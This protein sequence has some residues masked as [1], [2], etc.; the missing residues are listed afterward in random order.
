[1]S[2][3][4]A[5]FAGNALISVSLYETVMRDVL[6]LGSSHRDEQAKLFATLTD[7]QP[8]R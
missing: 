7:T 8:P 1:M 5:I 6:W 4:D 2:Q 3:Y